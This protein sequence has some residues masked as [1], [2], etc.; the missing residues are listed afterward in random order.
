MAKQPGR[1]LICGDPNTV[2]AH[3]FP[4]AVLLDIRGDEKT[5]VQGDRG[6]P[7]VR[8]SQNGGWDDTMLC[9]EHEDQIGSADDYAVRF[10]RGGSKNAVRVL[11][12]RAFAIQNSNPSKLIHFAYAS[13]WRAVNCQNGRV[14]KLNLGRYEHVIRDALLA[15]GPYDLQVLVGFSRLSL[16]GRGQL[17]LVINPHIVRM[18][19]LKCWQFVIGLFEFYLFTDRQR[20]PIDWDPYL[21]NNNN[22]LIISDGNLID[23]RDVPRLRPLF[24]SMRH[25]NNKP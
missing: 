2:K 18:R 1:C 22:P 17:A 19:G 23:I 9:K 24:Q 6:R 7:G 21:A 25:S 10:I 16:E 8:F 5:L 20:L 15:D 13:V 11:N 12:G 4:R 3:V 14:H